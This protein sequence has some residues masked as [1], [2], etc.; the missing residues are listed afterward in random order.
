MNEENRKVKKDFTIKQKN[1]D[2]LDKLQET[3]MNRSFII[4]SLLDGFFTGKTISLDLKPKRNLMEIQKVSIEEKR[5]KLIC[6]D[7]VPFPKG[8][9]SGIVAP[10]NTGKTFFVLQVCMQHI[11]TEIKERN[12]KTKVLAWLSEDSFEE[13]G[14]RFQY[15][16]ELMELNKKDKKLIS[17]NLDILD[18]ESEV[19]HFIEF[20]VRNEIKI[21][22]KFKLFTEACEKYDLIVIDPLIAFFG[23]DENNNSQAKYFMQLLTQ[24]ANTTGKTIILI[25][26]SSK[27][28]SN[29]RGASAFFDAFRFLI[30]L[31]KYTTIV[32]SKVKE[33]EELKHIRKITIIKDNMNISNFIKLNKEMQYSD[34]FNIQLF[35]KEEVSTKVETVEKK[36]ISNEMEDFIKS[37]KE[38]YP[39]EE[40]EEV[41]ID[42]EFLKEIIEL[43]EEMVDAEFLYE[44]LIKQH[45]KK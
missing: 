19:F 21:S 7:F 39:I 6:P 13:T 1:I 25:H 34:E 9:V 4:D 2:A 40:K 10:G 28:M 20:G 30:S 42:P 8:K 24:Y 3:G 31:E 32:K 16:S 14:D 45:G 18:S 38:E 36:I 11:L 29:T 22:E 12:N 15:I 37:I 27:G 41:D 23:G 17:D 33:I 26:H 43:N 5:E 44:E 35:K